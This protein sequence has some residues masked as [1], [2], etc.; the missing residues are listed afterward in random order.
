MTLLN[1]YLSILLSNIVDNVSSMFTSRSVTERWSH[2][3]GFQVEEGLR[4]SFKDR[5]ELDR[6]TGE[7]RIWV[8]KTSMA[9]TGLC[10]GQEPTQK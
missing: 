4:R 8:F 9:K 10:E 2:R 5:C 7:G 1:V 6:Q 3:Q